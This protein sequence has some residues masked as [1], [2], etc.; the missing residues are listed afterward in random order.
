MITLALLALVASLLVWAAPSSQAQANLSPI[1]DAG[2]DAHVLPEATVNLNGSGSFDP[3]D[4]TCTN[5]S[6]KWEVQT[7]PYDW[8]AIT[9]DTQQGDGTDG[10]PS[11]SVPSQAF[12]DKVSDSDPQKYEIVVQL[13]MTD[14]RGVTDSDTVTYS[15]NQRPVADIQLFAGL[16]D[17]DVVDAE[18]TVAERYSISAVIDGPGENGN[19]DNEWDIMEGALVI[20][21]GTGSTDPDGRSGVPAS[22]QWEQVTLQPSTATAANY[23]ASQTN[24][25]A[26][27]PRLVVGAV[28][29]NSGADNQSP[30][31]A[32]VAVGATG[33][34]PS[35]AT[36]GTTNTVYYRLNVCDI[37]AT[38][39]DAT[40]DGS[41]GSAVIK[42]VVNDSSIAPTVEIEADLSTASAGRDDAKPQETVGA[43]TGVENQFLVAAGSTVELTANVTDR[44]QAGYMAASLL[45]TPPRPRPTYTTAHTYVWSGA[46]AGA[47]DRSVATVRV[48][49][50]AEDGDTIDVMLTVTD[51][52]R[53]SAQ[54][55]I[56]LL[57]GTNTKPTAGGVQTNGTGIPTVIGRSSYTD[58][59]QNRKDGATVTLRGVGNDADGD[60]LIHAWVLRETPD[61]FGTLMNTAL[62]LFG[63]AAQA[64]Q[65]ATDDAGRAA[66]RLQIGQAL[67]PLGLGDLEEPEKPLFE[68]NGAF[69]DTV[70]FDVPELKVGETKGTLLIFTVIDSKGVSDSQ[71]VYIEITGDDDVPIADAGDDQQVDPEAF[72]RLNGSASSDPDVG[73]SVDHRWAYT[74]ATMDPAPD[75]RSP[76]SADEIDELDGWILTKDATAAGGFTYIVNAAGVLTDDSDKLQSTSSAY[77]YFDAPDLSGFNNLKLNFRLAVF[78]DAAARDVDGDGAT[79]TSD[80]TSLNETTLDMDLNGDGDKLDT[81]VT[82]VDE[83]QF[84]LDLNNNRAIDNELDIGTETVNEAAIR[85]FDTDTVTITVVNRYFSGNV[86][87][88]DFCVGPSLGGPSTYP[89]DSDGDGVADT[90]S[91]NTT[92]RA[93]VA[94]QNALETLANLNPIEFRDAV[95][96]ECNAPGFKQRDFGDDPADLETD[97]C[98]T[99]RVTPPPAAADPATAEEF[100]SGIITG[101]DFCTNHSLGGARTY[102]H[103]SDGDGVADQCSLSTTKREAVARQQALEEF[104]VSFTG[105]DELAALNRLIELDDDGSSTRSTDNTEDEYQELIDDHINATA[106]DLTGTGDPATGTQTHREYVEA[107]IAALE[108]VQSD[109]TRYSDALAAA[110]RALGSQDFGDAAS[111]LARD[112]CAPKSGPTGQPLS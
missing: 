9:N 70:S 43:I 29:N 88:P 79:T 73:D 106:T 108:A 32:D 69:T 96:A 8:I 92:R 13:T 74:G 105:A 86:T 95:N 87:G 78:D 66:A 75:E 103:D 34:L 35:F 80:V 45:A 10:G 17:R 51:S 27:Q 22:Y 3:D 36:A 112:A 1:A 59:I 63:A 110:C 5:C 33:L 49:R 89:F 2:T 100:F 42:I 82:T 76:L 90:C 23:A 98:E 83:A 25:A 20:L 101:P 16:R 67:E 38:D 19:R 57:V 71:L 37:D 62:P 107:R 14:S 18:A 26:D 91:L 81:S 54:V 11:F 61:D 111:A 46:N 50:D 97:V 47:T 99:G 7:G 64:L 15:I 93:T 55:S 77:P 72:V 85:A 102:A 84:G 56:Q 40:C 21:D 12:V 48:P 104:I 65:A 6:Y 94:R 31:V 53:A 24:F 68:L 4:A 58:G 41:T 44:D 30:S 28:V 60:P 39:D 109:A 52:S